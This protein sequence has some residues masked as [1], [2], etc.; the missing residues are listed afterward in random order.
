MHIKDSALNRKG[1]Y[2]ERNKTSN[3]DGFDWIHNVDNEYLEPLHG[4]IGCVDE[5][6]GPGAAEITQFAPTRHE[7]LV[8]VKHYE[9]EALDL[10]YFSFFYAT[11]KS[12]WSSKISFARR[13]IARIAALLGREEVQ[14]V[15]EKVVEEYGKRQDQQAWEIMKGFRRVSLGTQCR[16]TVRSMKIR[17]ALLF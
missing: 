13:R 15:V 6:N 2:M 11:Y 16:S 14:K 3:N 12:D 1:V 8:L 17:P 4:V 7:L 9:E 10:E 5:V